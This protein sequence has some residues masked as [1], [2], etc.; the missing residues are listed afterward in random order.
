MGLA[1]NKNGPPLLV[2]HR[3]ILF[4]RPARGRFSGS[5]ALGGG[6]KSAGLGLVGT[7]IGLGAVALFLSRGFRMAH[8]S[9]GFRGWPGLRRFGSSMRRHTPAIAPRVVPNLAARSSYDKPSA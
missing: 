7:T 8:V 3:H 1:Q 9:R 6:M 2:A 4:V 5:G